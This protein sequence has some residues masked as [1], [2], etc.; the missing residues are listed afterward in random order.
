MKIVDINIELKRIIELASKHDRQAQ[1]VLYNNYAS[2]LM[3]V[4]RQYV[5]DTHIAE[6]LL[7]TSFMKVFTYLPQYENRGS[8]DAWVRKIAVNECIS[9]LRNN[10]KINFIEESEL[11]PGDDIA[12]QEDPISDIQYMIDKLPEGCKMVFCLFVVEGYKHHEIAALLNISVGTS[13]SQMAYARKLLQ[14]ML[15][16]E[17][18]LCH[19]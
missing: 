10:R 2:K 6:D 18:K 3:S 12:V 1:K 13:K 9:Y 19:G 4:C 8:F 5:V 15:E 11:M 16:A 17:K 7:V 14:E